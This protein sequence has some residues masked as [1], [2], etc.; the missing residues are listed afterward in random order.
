M[1]LKIC[2][3]PRLDDFKLLDEFGPDF[4]LRLLTVRTSDKLRQLIPA[5]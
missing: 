1:Q 5:T 4:F 3:N 2:G